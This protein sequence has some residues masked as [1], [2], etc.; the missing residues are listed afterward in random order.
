M[1]MDL[2]TQLKSMI[3]FRRNFRSYNDC[4]W[5]LKNGDTFLVEID[6][7][8]FRYAII[9]DNDVCLYLLN[10]CYSDNYGDYIYPEYCTLKIKV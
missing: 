9:E 7:L 3:Y 6:R 10:E 2:R 8:K 5:E 4:G 1:N